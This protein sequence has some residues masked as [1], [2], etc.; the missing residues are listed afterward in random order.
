MLKDRLKAI[1]LEKGLTQT[2]IA[3]LLDTSYQNYANWERGVRTPKE[4][5]IQKLA[6]AL[7]VTPDYLTGQSYVIDLEPYSPTEEDMKAV[8]E[9]ID[10]YFSNKP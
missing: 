10:T 1:R 3:K 7:E 8:R 2:E 9:L 4:S 6:E 5:T